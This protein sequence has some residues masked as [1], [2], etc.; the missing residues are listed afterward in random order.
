MKAILLEKPQSYSE[1]MK[2]SISLYLVSFKKIFGLVCL[3]TL[4]IFIPYF[5][6]D[7]YGTNIF[8]GSTFWNINQLWL[9]VFNIIGL[10]FLVA[11]FWRIYCVIRNVH[12]PLIQDFK[13]GLHKVISIFI[14]LIIESAILFSIVLLI[15]GLQILLHQ[16]DILF[17][18]NLLSLLITFAVFLGELILL[19]Y[20]STLFFF[21]V[22]M[23]AIEGSSI[24]VALERSVL[25]VWNQWWRAFSVQVTPWIVYVIVISIL[26][27]LFVY[28]PN[29]S[30]ERIFYRL[31]HMIFF[32][33]FMPWVASLLMVQLHDLEIRKK[34]IYDVK[35]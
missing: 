35:L 17:K 29:F 10:F 23:I 14:V 28:L 32:F 34:N 2:S 21:L 19:I 31:I 4:T 25:L 6:T 33:F 22:P 30:Y 12:E 9:I 27:A 8:L 15:L 26:Q 5:I 20:I 16:Y 13:V 24:L 18:Q 7:I 3:L 1:L 11:I